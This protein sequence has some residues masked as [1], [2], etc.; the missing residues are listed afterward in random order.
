MNELV[1]HDTEFLIIPNGKYLGRFTNQKTDFN[2][3]VVGVS[4]VL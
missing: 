4:W 3:K 2:V 1:I